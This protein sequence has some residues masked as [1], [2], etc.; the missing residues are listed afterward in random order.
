MFNF[1][2]FRNSKDKKYDEDKKQETVEDEI[3]GLRL[4]SKPYWKS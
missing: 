4:K 1:G 2:K 3:L